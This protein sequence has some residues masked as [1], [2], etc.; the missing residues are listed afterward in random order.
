MRN[1]LLK[2]VKMID[3]IQNGYHALG[4]KNYIDLYYKQYGTEKKEFIEKY[5]DS[6]VKSL[7]RL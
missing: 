2:V 6:K 3:T 1:V 7:H 5:F 4:T